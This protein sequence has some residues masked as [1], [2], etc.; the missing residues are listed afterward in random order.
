MSTCCNK[1]IQDAGWDWFPAIPPKAQPCERSGFD[2]QEWIADWQFDERGEFAAGNAL[3]SAVIMQL[4]TDKRLPDDQAQRI[5]PF[6]RG[7][8]WGDAFAPFAMGSLLW[9]LYSE[10]LSDKTASLAERYVR[11]A[12][13]PLITQGAAMRQASIVQ[14]DKQRQQLLLIPMLFAQDGAKIYQ[15]QFSRMW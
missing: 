8:W 3:H 5:D 14:L 2:D 10:A 9:T 6:E 15:Q 4:F 7:G 1:I 12:L 11:E 13:Q